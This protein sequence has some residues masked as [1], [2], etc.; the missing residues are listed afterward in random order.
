MSYPADANMYSTVH[1]SN[2]GAAIDARIALA[3]LCGSEN[4]RRAAR[5]AASCDELTSQIGR[6]DWVYSEIQIIT[7]ISIIDGSIPSITAAPGK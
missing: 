4:G 2:H 6:A 5:P 3:A 1:Q 7:Y